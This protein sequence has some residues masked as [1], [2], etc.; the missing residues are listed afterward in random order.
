MTTLP[1]NPRYNKPAISWSDLV[2]IEASVDRWLN[3]KPVST[4]AMRYGTHIHALCERGLL[5]VPRLGNPEQTFTA[6]IPAGKGKQTFLA[7]GKIDDHDEDTIIDYK[8]CRTI[9]TQKKAEQHDQLK[10][11]AMLLWKT[12]GKLPTKGVIIALQTAWDEDSESPVLTGKQAILEVPIVLTDVLKV[13]ARFQR[14]YKKVV[15]YLNNK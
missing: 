12:T 3:K 8:T 6:E 10:A 9:W 14:G 4:P 11:Y 2:A 13:Q 1:I 7:V 5:D 15:D